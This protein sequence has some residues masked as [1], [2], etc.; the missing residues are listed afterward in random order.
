MSDT[1][2]RSSKLKFKGDESKKSK[3][4]KRKEL[5]EGAEDED[6]DPQGRSRLRNPPESHLTVSRTAL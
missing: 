3:K 2:I 5:Q 1:K 6:G 4:R